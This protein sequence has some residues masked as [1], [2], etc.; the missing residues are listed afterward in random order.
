MATAN[1]TALGAHAVVVGGGVA[2][3]TAAVC[4]ADAGVRV[5]LVEKR[6]M[7][8]GRASS[9]YDHVTGE[10]VDAV[11]LFRTDE[12]GRHEITAIHDRA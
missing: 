6:P 9:F 11:S 3:I 1:S 8:G 5:T 7:L 12:G 10:P 2:G 4:L